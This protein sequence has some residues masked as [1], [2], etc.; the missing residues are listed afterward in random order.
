MTDMATNRGLLFMG[1]DLSRP[2]MVVESEKIKR[3]FPQFAFKAS[4]GTV[5]SVEG[6]LE[7]NDG[8]YYYVKIKI[9]D[10]YP[11]TMPS[12]SLPQTAID[13]A[14]PHRYVSN[15]LCVMKSDQWTSNYS[16][17][18]MIAKA[19]IWINKYDVWQRTGHW[20]G[21]QQEH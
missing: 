17:A 19:A 5:T 1:D 3:Y 15:N 11:Y 6:Y 14:C 13:S 2:R 8:N 10:D 20:P 7:T 18:F 12:V 21:R 16:L 9:P 4:R